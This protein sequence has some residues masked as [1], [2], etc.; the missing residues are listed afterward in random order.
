MQV[1][2]IEETVAF[3]KRIARDYGLSSEYEAA[4]YVLSHFTMFDYN[5]S[6]RLFLAFCEEVLDKEVKLE[7]QSES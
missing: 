5:G 7:K 1:K 2:T 3:L 4:R 6:D